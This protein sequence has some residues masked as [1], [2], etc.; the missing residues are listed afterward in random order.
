MWKPI[1]DNSLRHRGL[2]LIELMAAL[3]I[4]V[5][6]IA[7][8][9][10]VYQNGKQS[11]NEAVCIGNMEQISFG[12]SLY[13]DDYDETY[14]DFHSDPLSAMHSSNLL[15]WHD[16][17]CR[18]EKQKP[19]QLCWANLALPY[20]SRNTKEKGNGDSIFFCPDDSDRTDRPVTSYEL[21]MYLAQ[22]ATIASLVDPSS[23][24][25][26]WEQW[27]YHSPSLY[28]EYDRRARLNTV[29]ADGHGISLLLADTTTA[30]FGMGPD[31]HWIFK[32]K[33]A[34]AAL[35]GHDVVGQ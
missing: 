8:I 29:F 1:A 11:A 7:I 27:D 25:E 30:R 18:G 12:L 10:P 5:I 15:Y 31:M 33:G 24:A 34:A 2:T 32:G 14:P 3:T 35:S 23:T 4:I 16:H 17:F 9:L 26:I 19:G 20:A 13:T 6:L 21:K 28:S 22:G